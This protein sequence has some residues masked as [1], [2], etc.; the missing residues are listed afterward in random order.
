MNTAVTGELDRILDGRLIVSRYQPIVRLDSGNVAGYEALARGPHGSPLEFPDRLFAAARASGQL[1][2]LDAACRAAALAGAAT[3]AIAGGATLFVNTEPDTSAAAMVGTYDSLLATGG[4]SRVVFEFTERALT[5]R[6][7]DVL[8]ATEQLRRLGGGIALDDVGVDPRSLALLPFLQPDVV[9]LDLSIVQGARTQHAARVMHAVGAYAERSGAAIVAEGIET[10]EHLAVA[11]SLGATHGQG[12]LFG[13][14]EP[15]PDTLG[16]TE[17]LGPWAPVPE[18]S[19]GQTAFQVV[20]A[21]GR[22][23]QTADKALL[24][25]LSRQLELQALSLD[26]EC[27]VLANLQHARH[28]TPATAARY[29]QLGGQVAFCGLIGSGLSE[30]PV[31]G[32]RG[33]SFAAGDALAREWSVVVISPHFSA[34]ML[35]CDLGDQG[36]DMERRFSYCLTYDRPL[37]AQA[38]RALMTSIES[39]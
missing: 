5:A 27:V 8:E 39:R 23:V 30:A 6:P 3:S 26:D 22:P 20:V 31:S 36:A 15:A 13:R 35:A 10:P 38:A 11:R 16:L 33:G 34:A 2:A 14:P 9:K 32:V 17:P 21:A 1:D 24:Y 19:M 4:G 37:V 12:W 7:A 25:S 18:P 28:L 29:H